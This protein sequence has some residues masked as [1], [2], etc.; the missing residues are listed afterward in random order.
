[1]VRRNSGRSRLRPL[2]PD[3]PTQCQRSD[4]H[5]YH[6]PAHT[7]S[8]MLSSQTALPGRVDFYAVFISGFPNLPSG[9]APSLSFPVEDYYNVYRYQPFSSLNPWVRFGIPHVIEMAGT[10]VTGVPRVPGQAMRQR[11]PVQRNRWL[12]VPFKGTQ[13]K[14]HARPR[15]AGVPRKS[16]RKKVS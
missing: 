3:H 6:R 11:G 10:P 12:S 14:F 2:T 16:W 15:R 1:M 7:P 13:S 4:P 9:C 5:P 8:P